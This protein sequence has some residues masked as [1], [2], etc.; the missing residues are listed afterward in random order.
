MAYKITCKNFFSN[1]RIDGK[2]ISPLNM[3]N[4]FIPDRMCSAS[5]EVAWLCKGFDWEQ[6]QTITYKVNQNSYS[7]IPKIIQ[8]PIP[9]YISQ[10]KEYFGIQIITNKTAETPWYLM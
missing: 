9:L 7:A 6:A 1:S 8:A 3:Q 4:I 10:L 2:I 5:D